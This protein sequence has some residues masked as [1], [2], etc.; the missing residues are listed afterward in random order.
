MHLHSTPHNR[1]EKL[2]AALEAGCY[3][4][5]A[6]IKGIGGC[7]MAGDDLVGNM[8]TEVMIDFFTKEGFSIDVDIAMLKKCSSIA[9]T[10]FV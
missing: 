5:D 8:D 9:S 6:A 3:R 1:E 10:I 7:P 2:F 4:F